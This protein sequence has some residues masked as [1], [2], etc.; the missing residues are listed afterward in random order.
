MIAIGNLGVLREEGEVRG[1]LRKAAK[2][3]YLREAL[4]AD[5][6]HSTVRSAGELA[7]ALFRGSCAALTK[8]PT[9]TV[10]SRFA[11]PYGSIPI[12]AYL[13]RNP[14]RLR[15]RVLQ[16][17]GGPNESLSIFG[18]RW[19]RVYRAGAARGVATITP[20]Y[21][22]TFHRSVHPAWG[23]GYAVDEIAA[24]DRFV[25]SSPGMGPVVLRAESGGALI[26]LHLPRLDRRRPMVL[27]NPVLDAPEFALKRI[28]SK[29]AAAV[30]IGTYH[31]VMLVKAQGSRL[32]PAGSEAI[33]VIDIFR[34]FFGKAMSFDVGK[35]LESLQPSCTTIIY[36][37]RDD[38]IGTANLP[39]LRRSVPALR[40]RPIVGMGHSPSDEIEL[41]KAESVVLQAV[42]TPCPGSAHR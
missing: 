5:C 3:A 8:G 14:S 6:R 17:V 15:I 24:Y 39:R 19:E 7:T 2:E 27:V 33:N 28:M 25:N 35:A 11:G 20:A 42:Q 21:V 34:N 26:A 30:A 40:V 10:V 32:L 9:M 4:G 23:F 36:G 18:S 38:R 29:P 37:T 31:S 41:N 12:V 13:P 1:K 22:G 16:I